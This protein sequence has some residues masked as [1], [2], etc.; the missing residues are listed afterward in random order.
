[1]AWATYL[2]ALPGV[3]G[4]ASAALNGDDTELYVRSGSTVRRHSAAT[5]AY[6]GEFTL[7]GMSAASLPIRLISSWRRIGLA[8]SL[9]TRTAWFQSGMWRQPDWR[10][11]HPHRD[12]ERVR[13]NLLLRG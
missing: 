6:L 9:P 2:F 4:Q 13:Y 10:V 12:A 5:G 7:N 3:D 8:A 11:R 1:M